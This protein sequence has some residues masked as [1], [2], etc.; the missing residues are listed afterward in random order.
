MTVGCLIHLNKPCLSPVSLLRCFEICVLKVLVGR[1]S[2]QAAR[3]FS[4]QL[5]C[6]LSCSSGIAQVRSRTGQSRV[7]QALPLPSCVTSGKS[8]NLSGLVSPFETNCWLFVTRITRD[9]VGGMPTILST[10]GPSPSYPHLF[11]ARKHTGWEWG[12]PCC[13]GPSKGVTLPSSKRPCLLG[14]HCPFLLLHIPT[15]QLKP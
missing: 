14:T 1:C 3:G 15:S 9:C 8:P 6:P 10:H 11:S 13:R 12:S 4:V 5:G 2:G 7:L